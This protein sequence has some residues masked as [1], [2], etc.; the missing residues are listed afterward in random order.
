MDLTAM[1]RAVL[2]PLFAV[3]ALGLAAHCAYWWWSARALAWGIDDWAAARRAEGYQ[4]SLGERETAG[5]PLAAVVR[6]GN[7]AI[8]APGAAWSW[9]AAALE[10]RNAPWDP[11]S[12]VLSLDGEHALSD[13]DGGMLSAHVDSGEVSLSATPEG[14]LDRITARLGPFRLDG[15]ALGA[16]AGRSAVVTIAP[17]GAAG[18]LAL[19]EVSATLNGLVLPETPEPA[20]GREIARIVL[21]TRV[22]GAIAAAPVAQA[23]AHWRDRGGLVE[24]RS[25]ALAW[26]PLHVSGSGALVL[27]QALQPQAE[28]QARVRGWR[29]ALAALTQSGLV[30]AEDAAMAAL[31]L[32]VMAKTPED[33]GAPVAEL[34]VSVRD[35]RVFAGPLA[36]T[37]LPPIH[38][39]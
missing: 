17:D 34:P 4:V 36:I 20:F 35:Q 6:L 23:L 30:T 27:D 38:W 8:V 10:V 39:P 15:P 21:E 24:I 37:A 31:A 11:L 29:D 18:P 22:H 1:R 26:G 13:R 14:A 16:L 28:L 5:F 19:F 25:G 7:P 33:G 32:A 2:V 3:L 12:I 9:R